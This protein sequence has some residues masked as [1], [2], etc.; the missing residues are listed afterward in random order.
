VDREESKHPIHGRSR[1]S[2]NLPSHY[3]LLVITNGPEERQPG[4]LPGCRA[5]TTRSGIPAQ[6]PT[7]ANGGCRLG[8]LSTLFN[9]A[10]RKKSLIPTATAADERRED[11]Q[12]QL[13]D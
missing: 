10:E 6:A 12:Q 2:R 7:G 1:P 13:T 9:N 4:D 8:G 3:C 5:R 11:A